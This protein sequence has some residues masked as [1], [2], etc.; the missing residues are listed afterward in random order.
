MRILF[1]HQNMPGQFVHL[2][3]HLARDGRHQV[4]CIGRRSDFTPQGVGR[5]VYILPPPT[6]EPNLFV[7]PL[8]MAARHGVQVVRACEALIKN[9]YR[10]DLIVAHP[11][12]GESLYLRDVYPDVPLLLYCEFFY[13]AFGAD[14][15]F[16]PAD[17]QDLMANCVTRTRNAHLL[18]ALEAA[19][20]GYSPTAW[21]RAQHPTAFRPRISVAF[22]G[23]DTDAAKPDRAATLRLPGGQTLRS[24]DE[25]VTYVARGLEPYRG[26]PTFMRALPEILRRR[27]NAQIVIAGEDDAFYGKP[28]PNGG[29]WREVLQAELSMDWGRVHFLGRIGRSDYLRL[30]QVSAAHIYL[31]VPFVLSWSM[32]EAMSAGCLVIGSAT[33]PVLEVIEDERNGLLVDFFA[34]EAIAGRVTEALANPD[35][36]KEIRQNARWTALSGYGLDLCLPRQ[37]RLLEAVAA[38]Q[39]PET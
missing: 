2:I 24:G 32:L 21:Q 22:D 27:P 5:V 8:E 33:P 7:S 1:I 15:N 13:R 30:L 17:Q 12:W 31:T 35:A 37:A 20:W 4:A 36:F 39:S 26:F 28:P 3:Q 38:G 29:S 34:P 11:G 9:G 23:I 25:V 16:D 18:L 14:V 10:P 19:D 6:I